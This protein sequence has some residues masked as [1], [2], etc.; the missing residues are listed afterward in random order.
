MHKIFFISSFLYPLFLASF[1]RRDGVWLIRYKLLKM[2]NK[3]A[4][5]LVVYGRR[6][7]VCVL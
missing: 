1:L 5:T 4:A 2:S 6:F 3:E 7:S